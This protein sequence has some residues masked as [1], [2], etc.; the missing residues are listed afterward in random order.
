MS[1]YG[2]RDARVNIERGEQ[3]PAGTAGVVKRDAADAVPGAPDI[4]GPVDVA[5]L[6]RVTCPR[7][8]DERVLLAADADAGAWPGVVAGL[9]LAAFG[10]P[11]RGRADRRKRQRV[12]TAVPLQDLLVG[13]RMPADAL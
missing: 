11:E 10:D 12:R 8:E 9:V 1:E 7:G 4:E 3:R 2:H 5:R 6:D 13:E